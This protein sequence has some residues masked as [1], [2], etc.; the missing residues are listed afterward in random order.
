MLPISWMG[1]NANLPVVQSI[2]PTEVSFFKAKCG[3]NLISNGGLPITKLG[4]LISTQSQPSLANSQIIDFKTGSGQFF[5]EIE[6]LNDNT[7]YYCRGFAENLAGTS[8]ASNIFQFTTKN[9]Y[10]VG[11]QGPAGGVIF[12]SKLDTLG[13]WNF[14][15]SAPNDLN[16]NLPWGLNTTQQINLSTSIGAGKQ[17]TIDIVNTYG[18]S[19]SNYAAKSCFTLIQGGCDDWFLPSRDEMITLY[20]NLYLVNL[21]SFAT[22]AR[23]W[24]SSD[25]DYFNQNAWCQ[26]MFNSSGTVNSMTELKSVALKIRP[27]R[28]F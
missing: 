8:F 17:N 7:I 24:T 15:E 19:G 11:E 16:L 26:K 13:G 6:K 1:G 25:D 3:S 4:V 14:L 28:C 9:F 20:Q 22:G 5:K 27:I 21:G 18:L 23:Y 2:Q 12:Y 10:D